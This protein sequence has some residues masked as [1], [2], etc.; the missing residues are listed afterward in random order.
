MTPPDALAPGP[1]RGESAIALSWFP[2][3][4]CEQTIGHGRA[5]P[6]TRPARGPAAARTPRQGPGHRRARCVPR[7]PWGV[8]GFDG[9]VIGV[10]GG[11]ATSSMPRTDT[12][13]QACQV[14]LDSLAAPTSARSTMDMRADPRRSR[15]INVAKPL[16]RRTLCKGRLLVTSAQRA[17]FAGPSLDADERTRTSTQLPGHGP[18]PCASTNSA[19][20]A[21]GWAAKISH[22]RF[23]YGWA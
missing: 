12:V 18:E 8:T 15:P 21:W 20:S 17:L 19:T 2:R 14:E 5:S 4:E 3:G 11:I 16:P 23:G 22:Y 7:Q 13:A 6:R 9:H 1:Q 10:N